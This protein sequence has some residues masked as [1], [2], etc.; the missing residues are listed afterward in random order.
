STFMTAGLDLDLVAGEAITATYVD[1]TDPTDTSSDTIAILAGALTVDA[2]Y[3][4]PNPFDAQ[5]TFGF[6]GAGI[7]STMT[8]MVYDL[9]GAKRWEQ[10]A[11]DATKIV[12]DG[13]GDDGKPLANGAYLYVITVTDG[14]NTFSGNGKA[15]VYR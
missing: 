10:T 3:A 6:R 14:T 5:V 7:A 1:P 15:F 9:A 11:T 2:F 12:W 4:A 8:V 13:I